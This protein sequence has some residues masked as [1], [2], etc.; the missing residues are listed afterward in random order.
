MFDIFAEPVATVNCSRCDPPSLTVYVIKTAGQEVCTHEN[1]PS[2]IT[3]Q[4]ITRTAI[5][6]YLVPEPVEQE[7][8]AR[9]Q[10]LRRDGLGYLKVA[11]A[12]NEEGRATMRGGPWQSMSMRSVPQVGDK[13]AA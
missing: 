11:Q 10:E 9:L 8:L 6:G 13:M 1:G 3:P 7:T 12:P 2:R 5:D 4:A